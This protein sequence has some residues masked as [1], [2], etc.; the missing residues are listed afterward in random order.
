MV[1]L[2]FLFCRFLI[3]RIYLVQLSQSATKLYN[4]PANEILSGKRFSFSVLIWL[5]L[6]E[7]NPDIVKARISS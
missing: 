1:I 6:R 2:I 3:K 5:T 7:L 4:S